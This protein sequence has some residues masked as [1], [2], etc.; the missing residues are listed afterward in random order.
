MGLN[1]S[2]ARIPSPP[3]T[4]ER[5]LIHAGRSSLDRW[6][7]HPFWGLVILVAILGLA[8]LATFGL[9]L[10]V[11]SYL[12]NNLVASL[13]DTLTGMLTDAPDWLRELLTHGLLGGLGTALSL[14]PVLLVLFVVL[15][16]LE[17]SGYLVRASLVMD[18]YLRRLG[19]PGR[20][21]VPLS[22][23][24]GCNTSAVAGCRILPDRRSR[25]LTMLLVPFIPCT[26]GL[27]SITFLT[28]T[29]F[30]KSASLVT[31][32]LISLSLLLLILTAKL[33]GWLHPPKTPAILQ[34][35][36]PANR[37]PAYHLPRGRQVIQ[38]VWANMSEFLVKKLGVQIVVLSTLVWSLSYF[39]NGSMES[40]YL[41]AISRWLEPAGAMIGVHDWRF[42]VAL[43]TSI[44]SR[45]NSIAVLGVLFASHSGEIAFSAQISAAL[46]PAA[47]LAYL[48]VQRLFI[49]CANSLVAIRQDSGSLRLPLMSIGLMLIISISMGMLVYRL[50][51][52]A[53]LS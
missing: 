11:S 32:G 1:Q 45:E 52:L 27:A 4:A 39:P 7:L 38:Y 31:W 47:G 14:A 44:F 43:I 22:M 26:S 46:T 5:A 28:P 10:P 30:G 18:R 20:A 24:F 8:M 12:Q 6:V 48:T 35:S 13:R 15:G 37:L 2:P 49:P 50:A 3:T 40:S 21:C 17:E 25:L 36:F 23:G 42:I 33:V 16:F 9:A 41:A 34:P 51:L 19:L 29:L 53:G